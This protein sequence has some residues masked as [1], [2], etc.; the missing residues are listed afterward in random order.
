MIKRNSV[1]IIIP[2]YNEEA[3]LQKGVLDKVGNFVEENPQIK[4]VIIVDDG[5]EDKTAQIIKSQYLPKFKKFKYVKIPH[6][7]KASAVIT[8]IQKAKSEFVLFTDMDLATPIEESK[9]LIQA[10]KEGWHIAIGSR[11]K[12]RKGAPITRKIMAIGFILIR[13]FLLNLGKIKDTQC[14]FKAFKRETALKIISHMKVFH[15]KTKRKTKGA[16]VTAGFD[17]EFLFVAK[18]LGYKIKEIPVEWRHVETRNVN[19]FKDTIETLR[20]ILKIKW[21]QIRNQYKHD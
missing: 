18:L 12:K 6:Q 8:G 21:Y 9:K 15:P 10:I 2:C 4:E 5:S 11:D 19:V 16:S 20:D 17:L 1:S 14:G 3:N 7:G 13:N